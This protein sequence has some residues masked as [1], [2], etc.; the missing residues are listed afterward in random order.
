ML[1]TMTKKEAKEAE[2][3]TTPILNLLNKRDDKEVNKLSNN[4]F[5]MF[6]WLEKF[7]TTKERK[8]HIKITFGNPLY[9][10]QYEYKEA[11]WGFKYEQ[12]NII[13]YYSIKGFS[14]QVSP[15]CSCG[16]ALKILKII[17]SKLEK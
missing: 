17:T 5:K 2:K 10:A 6:K 1:Y 14:I 11:V 3:T 8:K 15:E 13:V 16:D 7:T 9:H 4:I 12:I